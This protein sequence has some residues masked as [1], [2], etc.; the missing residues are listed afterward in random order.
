M[1]HFPVGLRSDLSVHWARWL[2]NTVAKLLRA[3]RIYTSLAADPTQVADQYGDT[4]MNFVV[5][6]VLIPIEKGHFKQLKKLIY[7]GIVDL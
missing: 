7:D 2:Q 3:V 4:N 5:L 6:N 1:S